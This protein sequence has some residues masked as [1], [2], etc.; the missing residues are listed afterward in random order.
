MKYCVVQKDMKKWEISD[1]ISKAR[2]GIYGVNDKTKLIWIRLNYRYLFTHRVLIYT[3]V[4]T[5]PSSS[6]KF[7]SYRTNRSQC[8]LPI[9]DSRFWFSKSRSQKVPTETTTI[10]RIICSFRTQWSRNLRFLLRMFEIFHMKY[11][12]TSTVFVFH[13]NICASKTTI[14]QFACRKRNYLR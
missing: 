2:S 6:C 1:K 11:A 5:R 12:R 3:F 14:W 10:H 7:Y 13:L 8:C 9:N 4:F